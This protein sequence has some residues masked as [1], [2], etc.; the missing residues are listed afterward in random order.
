MP[1]LIDRFYR[2]LKNGTGTKAQAL[3]Q[4]QLELIH[5]GKLA[6]PYYWAPF[7]LVGQP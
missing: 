3:R 6:H 2:H 5:S 4:A 1:E 7:V